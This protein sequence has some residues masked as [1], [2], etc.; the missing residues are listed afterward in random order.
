M[1]IEGLPQVAEIPSLTRGFGH[2]FN[3]RD[4]SREDSR[5]EKPLWHNGL[6]SHFFRGQVVGLWGSAAFFLQGRIRT[7][8][9]LRA[10]DLAL[11][12]T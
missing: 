1:G 6:S 9:P 4:R 8:L 10:L 5:D 3:T 11:C 2:H 7:S 12:P